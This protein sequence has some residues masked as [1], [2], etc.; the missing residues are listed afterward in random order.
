MAHDDKFFMCPPSYY[1]VEYVI[2]PWMKGNLGGVDRD[3]AV[4][5]WD[6]L[7]R[8][9]SKQAEVEIIEPEKG[10][11]DMVFTANADKNIICTKNTMA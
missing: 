11:P 4:R 2:N 6:S 9:L 10:F 5:E 1:D 3:E 7:Y 8:T